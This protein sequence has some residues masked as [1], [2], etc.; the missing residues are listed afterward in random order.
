MMVI[1]NYDFL[2]PPLF[3]ASISSSLSSSPNFH[4]GCWWTHKKFTRDFLKQHLHAITT[5]IVWWRTFYGSPGS[6]IGHAFN[7]RINL[8]IWIKGEMGFNVYWHS[9]S[10]INHLTT[11]TSCSARKRIKA[12]SLLLQLPPQ[13]PL[14]STHY[15]YCQS[16]CHSGRK[17]TQ[18]TI[19]W[20]L[21]SSVSV[22]SSRGHQPI[23]RKVLRFFTGLSLSVYVA[24]PEATFHSSSPCVYVRK[25]ASVT[26]IAIWVG[27]HW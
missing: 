7:L 19:Y 10:S 17:N 20:F 14:K 18:R 6:L 4:G 23:G 13:L 3:V 15:R 24:Y 26:V 16:Q 1:M 12:L 21:Y 2:H 27:A 8:S 25:S 22:S 9:K 5:G 11:R